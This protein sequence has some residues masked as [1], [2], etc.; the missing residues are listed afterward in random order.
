MP[1]AVKH[2][3][4]EAATY[5]IGQSLA[6]TACHPKIQTSKGKTQEEHQGK[7]AHVCPEISLHLASSDIDDT[8]ADIN[9]KQSEDDTQQTKR[10]T[11]EEPETITFA[12]DVEIPELL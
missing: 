2:F 12:L 11:Q 6:H 7:N 1:G 10:Q 8:L 5:R 4:K 9:E 3:T